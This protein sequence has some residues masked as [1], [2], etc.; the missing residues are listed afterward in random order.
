MMYGNSITLCMI[1]DM[2][3]IWLSYSTAYD[4]SPYMMERVAA[5]CRITDTLVHS[6]LLIHHQAI[7]E[8]TS[9]TRIHHLV[10]YTAA[11]TL[12]QLWCWSL[13][14]HRAEHRNVTLKTLQTL[15]S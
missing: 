7:K 13:L 2:I 9:N 14:G 4:T 15:S 6:G 1:P 10:R 5:G 12:F 8:H 11:K 3:H